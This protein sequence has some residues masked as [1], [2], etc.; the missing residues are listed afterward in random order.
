MVCREGT[1]SDGSASL[2]PSSRVLCEVKAKIVVLAT[3]GF[4]GSP[5]LT[6]QYLGPGADNI[7]VRSNRGSVGDGLKLAT[8][9][10]A[11]T[12]RGMS[13]YYGHLLASPL[14]REDVDPKDYLP[15][16]QYRTRHPI[17]FPNDKPPNDLTPLKKVGIVC[18]ST[19]LADDLQTSRQE[20]RSS[21]NTL[22]AKRSVA[23]LSCSSKIN[24]R[25]TAV[26]PK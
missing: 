14:R 17:T 22:P 24:P 12:S 3:G 1:P 26:P 9:V 15:L 18:S 4:Q 10:G 2:P 8:E 19:R 20:M 6:S 23:A 11:G 16:A 25:R 7:F 13:T 5:A 21:I